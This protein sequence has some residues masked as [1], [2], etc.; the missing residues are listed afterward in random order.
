MLKQKLKTAAAKNWEKREAESQKRLLEAL[1]LEAAV[2]A[3]L[4]RS[5]GKQSE[6]LNKESTKVKKMWGGGVF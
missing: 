2:A 5:F 1:Q 3:P 4:T 6:L